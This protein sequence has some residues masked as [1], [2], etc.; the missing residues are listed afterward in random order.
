[1]SD[2][3]SILISTANDIGEALVEKLGGEGYA[4]SVWDKEYNKLGIAEVD[5]APALSVLEDSSET[6]T[7]RGSIL[8]ST[9]NA[10]GAMLNKKYNTDRG[11]KP[12]EWAS[13][14]SKLAPLPEKSAESAS[15]CSIEDGADDVPSR[16]LVVTIP[17]TLT[18]ISEVVENQAGKNLLNYADISTSYRVTSIT[19]NSTG[20]FTVVA[21][22]LGAYI[23]HVIKVKAGQVYSI[24]CTSATNDEGNAT[25]IGAVNVY[26]GDNS[27]AT[28]L[29]DGASINYSPKT[30]TPTGNYIL[31]R[32]KITGGLGAGTGTIVEPRLNVGS[33]ASDYVPYEE[34]TT[35]TADL[36]RTVHGGTADF[37][38][39]VG[40]ET[41]NTVDMGTLTWQYDSANTRFFTVDLTSVIKRGASGWITDLAVSSPY[42]VASGTAND[43]T[44]SEY[45]TTGYVYIKDTD[46]TDPTVF[47]NSLSGKYLTYPLA[48]PVD[49]TFDGQ[50]IPTKDGYN[51][52]WSDQGNTALDYYGEPEPY[53]RGTASGVIAN[54]Q[55][56]R[57]DLP[58]TQVKAN[59][60]PNLTGVESVEVTKAGKNLLKLTDGTY[61]IGNTGAAATILNG[62]ISVTGTTVNSGGRTTRLSDY[63]ILSAGTYYISPVIST[64]PYVRSYL[65]RKSDN[66]VVGYSSGSAFTVTE[67]TEVYYGINLENEKTYDVTFSPQLEVGSSATEYTPYEEPAV[68]TADLGE[69]VYGGYA[70]LVSGEVVKDCTKG[71]MSSTYLSGLNSDYIGYEASTAYF[72]N[73]PS[74]WVR[75]WNYQ[76]AAPRVSGG[77]KCVCYEFPVSM[78]NTTIFSAQY[79]IY[80]DVY[81]KNITSVQD[82]IDYVEDLEQNGKSLDITYE[83]ATPTESS[84][85]P[86]VISPSEG[87][88]NLWNNAGG[89]TDVEYFIQE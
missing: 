86:Q 63:F 5:S 78:H 43:K 2:R 6:G 83:V 34:P 65:N 24:K 57:T 54:V 72:N 59:I 66:T 80:F 45:A 84:I 46:Y 56:A 25:Q 33:T 18:G 37:V 35:Y 48:T 13:A 29:L 7:A 75:N 20:S 26:D 15:I 70:D 17:P 1:M 58:F 73:H 87:V 55:S 82:F 4:P 79:R 10:I 67:D 31:V 21:S 60:A 40:S 51:A 22:G 23:D 85:T 50:E 19:E 76:T 16:S 52:F 27:D 89:D 61:T 62:E 39:G 64:S 12:K 88:N 11:F 41:H 42:T 53:T 14:A 68:Y 47:K 8:L 77:I 81:G 36:D 71:S 49:F 32:N 74:I 28:L 3:G 38:N 30:F 9:A 69:P 44:V